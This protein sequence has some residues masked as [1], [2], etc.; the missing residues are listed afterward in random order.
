MC[1]RIGEYLFWKGG[2]P[3]KTVGVICECNPPHGGHL[4]LLECARRAGADRILCVMSGCFVQRGE[5]A[6]ADA[7]ARAEI[8]VREGADAVVELP[9]PYAFASAEYFG[10]A[11]VDILDRL[12]C[13]EI[14]FGSETGDVS[15]LLSLCEIAKGEEFAALYREKCAKGLGTAQAYFETLSELGGKG[16]A[17]SPNDILALSYLR[18][19]LRLD[20]S[21]RPVAIR[22]VGSG[23]SE[24]TVARESFP[25]A[26]ALRLLWE[27]EGIDALRPHLTEAAWEVLLRESEAG[28]APAS[29]SLAER[30]IIG[31][32]RLAD[33]ARL[34][35]LAHLGGGLSGR[36]SHAARD[37]DSL[38]SMISL[39][40]SKTY[41]DAGV[42]RAILYA[43]L[44]IEK[45]DLEARAAYVRLL[46]AN[47]AGRDAVAAARKKG[48]LPIL[49]RYGDVARVAGAERQGE[50]EER[51]VR[52]YSLMLPRVESAKRLLCHSPVI[53]SK[54]FSKK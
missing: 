44:G 38:A 8:L 7:Y 52:L 46:A 27:T 2:K 9:A 12:G 43:L 1:P 53:I 42:R 35:S 45:K 11:G 48:S 13:D 40:A 47:G 32:L 34:S 20:S 14:W 18:A 29:L 17:L 33:T 6:V 50:I 37:A 16:A 3:L 39:A 21:M 36:L 31:E 54:E 23:Y 15:S 41:P 19:L 5:A 25:S 10:M 28:R 24:K 30:L 4:Y 26:T 49:A 51:T 22:R